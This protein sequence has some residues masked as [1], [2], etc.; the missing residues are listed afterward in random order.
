MEDFKKDDWVMVFSSPDST[1]V[2]ILKLKLA[3]SGIDAVIF[4]HQDS[5]LTS[6]NDVNYS[7]TLYVHENDA[8][9]AKQII[10]NR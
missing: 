2:N 9:K 6:L 3:D 5:M 7:V 1:D 8:A 10:E 4:N